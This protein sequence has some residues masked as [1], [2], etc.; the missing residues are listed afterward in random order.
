MILGGCS[1]STTPAATGS[2]A[3]AGAEREVWDVYSIQDS[4]VGYIRTTLRHTSRAG[5]ELVEVAG[6]MHA[7][8]PRF[9]D[10]TVQEIEYSDTETPDGK[11]LDFQSEI[12]QGPTPLRTSGAVRGG[13][14]ELQTSTAGKN[15]SASIA[16]PADGGGFY[17]VEESLLRRPMQP[18]QQRTVR[19]LD[20]GNQ[21][22]ETDLSARGFERVPLLGGSFE[23]LRIDT[24][25]RLP[26]GHAMQGAV[27]CDRAGETLK[28]HMDAMNM[29]T[30]RVP[31]EVA[32]AEIGP[33]KFDLGR[34]FS[35][36]VARPLPEAHG[37]Q[38]IRYGVELAGG[39]PAKAFMSGPSQAVKSTGPHTAEVTVYG[40][41]PG[42]SDGNRQA[43]ADPPSDAS[44]Q[45][46]NFIQSDDPRIV[47]QAQEAAGK[48][49]DPW[50]VAVALE[51]Y[52]HDGVKKKDF[53]EA[54][55]TAADVARSHE[56]DCKAHAVYLAA[57]ARARGLPARVAV[58]L[59]YLQGSDAFAY[60]MWTEIYLD[61]RWIPLDGT[62]GLGGIGAGH[63]KLGQTALEG[64]SAYSSFLPLVEITGRLK[65]DVLDVE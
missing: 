10:T 18:G 41:R 60:H 43:A 14:L 15:V 39:D 2:N 7:A 44:R 40:I 16:W 49:T 30:L 35:V 46:N 65:I 29:E 17:A 21:M 50:K 36:R 34:D 26:D 24:V 52:V 31:K 9:G 56:G 13:K 32:L 53:K 48:E 6:F 47:A 51:R 19:A 42:R 3:A 58:G 20:I 1:T 55:A 61:Q 25:M 62:L 63:L 37:S 28:T 5:R 57:L 33:V 4:R 12:R 11:L 22:V 27:W 64:V 54:F 38:R 59:V 23:L 8:V 45:P